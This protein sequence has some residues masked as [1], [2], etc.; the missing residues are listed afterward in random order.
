MS[1]ADKRRLLIK[2]L[3]L[4]VVVGCLIGFSNKSHY[5]LSASLKKVQDNP[6]VAVQTQQNVPLRVSLITVNS[7]NPREP[8]LI[9]TVENISGKPIGAYAIRHSVRFGQAVTEGV[10]VRNSNSVYSILQVGGSEQGFLQGDSYSEAV[11]SIDLAVD[12]VEFSDGTAWGND[13]FKTAER[14][15][16]QRAG[17][18][19]ETA[20]LLK[21][22]Q[23]KGSAALME[24]ISTE[25]TDIAAPPKQSPAWINGFREGI[26]FKRGRLQ[27]AQKQGGITSIT[28]ELKQPFDAYSE[29][30]TN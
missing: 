28:H 5:S 14:L 1:Q 11:Q 15:S 2:L 27:R 19:A 10:T 6:S 17:A 12:Y 23:M 26:N 7:A 13:Q 8:E 25:A 3:T 21:L 16:G 24:A 18:K 30:G 4:S 9:Y 29:R 20:R 22:K